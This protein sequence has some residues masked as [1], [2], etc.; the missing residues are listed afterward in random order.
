[1]AMAADH[2]H[3]GIRVN[4]VN[5]GTVDTP[6]VGRLLAAAIVYLASPASASTTGTALPVDG[7]MFGLRLRS[8]VQ[9]PAKE[10]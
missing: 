4:C 1:M 8:P 3:E 6:C 7:G 2:V 5:L 10:R 9:D